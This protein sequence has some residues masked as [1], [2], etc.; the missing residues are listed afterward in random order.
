LDVD[1]TTY[2]RQYQKECSGNQIFNRQAGSTMS[3]CE[4][5]C[6]SEP[7]CKAV[8]WRTQYSYNCQGYGADYVMVYGGI[9]QYCLF[10]NPDPPTEQPSSEPTGQ[11]TTQP[12]SQ[13]S[14]SPAP[15]TGIEKTLGFVWVVANTCLIGLVA[16]NR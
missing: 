16:F 14:P 11:P 15:L 5:I 10:Q 1:G 7:L 4:N 9:Y 8:T 2:T 13:P 3:D 6:N 12:T